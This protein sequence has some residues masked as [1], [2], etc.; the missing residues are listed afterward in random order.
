MV[1]FVINLWCH[2]TKRK[3]QR[4]SSMSMSLIK[5]LQSQHIIKTRQMDLSLLSYVGLQVHK[6]SDW[7]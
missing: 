2:N 5:L 4:D 1:F 7:A 6:F 3:I